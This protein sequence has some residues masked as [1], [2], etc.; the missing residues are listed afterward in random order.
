MPQ[1]PAPY[2]IAIREEGAMVNAYWTST[3]TME[4]AELVASIQTRMLRDDPG[5]WEGF[6]IMAQAMAVSLT[7]H[8]LG[9]TPTGLNVSEAA[10]HERA[11]HA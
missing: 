1:T 9:V 7:Q 11:G 6:Q 10:Q 2:R 3:D 4:G 8:R 5:L